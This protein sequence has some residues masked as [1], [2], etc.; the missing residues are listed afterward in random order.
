M[1]SY[2][3]IGKWFNVYG[4]TTRIHWYSFVFF[5]FLI[6]TWIL[7][8]LIFSLLFSTIHLPMSSNI[9]CHLSPTTHSIMI[10][11]RGSIYRD[12]RSTNQFPALSSTLRLL[13]SILMYGF[14]I[15]L[16]YHDPFV[17]HE[18]HSRHHRWVSNVYW[19]I[20]AWMFVVI[21]SQFGLGLHSWN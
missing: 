7:T 17:I 19:H 9:K 10:L 6:D 14:H 3:L 12:A 1:C 18:P 21:G 13:L 16:K 2:H 20:C 8:L 4:L 11:I 5:A 15:I